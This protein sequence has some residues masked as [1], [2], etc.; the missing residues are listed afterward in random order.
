[1]NAQF[2]TTNKKTNFEE[3]KESVSEV[4]IRI[5]NENE[6]F[7]SDNDI[8]TIQDATKI[9]FQKIEPQE[10]ESI[11]AGQRPN[12]LLQPDQVSIHDNFAQSLNLLKDGITGYKYNFKNN[13]F[14]KLTI[15]LSKDYKSIMYIDDM[16]FNNTRMINL[17]K[18]TGIIYGGLSDNFCKHRKVLRR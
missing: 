1:M 17:E 4:I 8:Q 3:D 18:F 14:R 9:L 11:I 10:V 7:G 12:L 15:K 16:R 13:K 6:M 5:E 2:F